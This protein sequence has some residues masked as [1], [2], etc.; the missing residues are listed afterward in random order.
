MVGGYVLQ[1]HKTK[2]NIIVKMQPPN[3]YI[4]INN[5]IYICVYYAL[6]YLLES[7]HQNSN[8]I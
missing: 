6:A 8:A 3:I 1:L 7:Y 4:Y 2:N 5:Y